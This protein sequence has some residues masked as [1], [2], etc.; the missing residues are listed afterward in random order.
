MSMTPAN[1]GRARRAL[2]IVITDHPGGAERVAFG[3]AAEL[4]ARPGWRVEVMIVCSRL[5]Q[6][7]SQSVL[8]PNVHVSYG[9]AKN[10]YLSFPVLPLR[11]LGGRFDM[12]FTTHVYVNALLSAMRRSK[13]IRI[14]RLIARES[15]SVF[16]RWSGA[17]RSRFAWMYRLYGDE[18]LLV[19]Q[20]GYMAD[21]VRPW[22]PSRSAG[23]LRVV[24]NP[25]DLVAVAAGVAKPL[26]VHT[27]NLLGARD[28]ILFCGRLIDVKQP[29]LAL[30]AFERLIADGYA[31]QLVFVGAGP[32]EAD[33]R[34]EVSRR[35]LEGKV[36]FLGQVSNPFP[37]MA[38]CQFG[39]VPSA[40]EGF[41]NV[42]LEMMACGLRKIVVTPCAGDLDKLPG[43]TVTLSFAAAELAEA[44][45]RA[46]RDEED[47]SGT[48]RTT[49]A[50]RSMRSYLDCLLDLA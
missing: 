33:V 31:V 43:V 25:V 4:A 22:L 6:S 20:T 29:L 50:T 10:W 11:L 30:D 38:A 8:P 49:A 18:D 17:R 42:V 48:Y 2:V 41:P 7:F 5:T 24:P 3:L 12:V 23:H 14:G 32:L 35:V 44:L 45:G 16:D 40:K 19:A 9:P 34:R 15:T 1:P 26:D 27:R 21:H 39:I 13:L 46:I 28:N 36:V 47:W 37:I